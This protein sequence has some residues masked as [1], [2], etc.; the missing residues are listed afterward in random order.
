MDF[1]SSPK[2]LSSA[3]PTICL[4]DLLIASCALGQ[5]GGSRDLSTSSHDLLLFQL[6]GMFFQFV[7]VIATSGGNCQKQTKLE[8]MLNFYFF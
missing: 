5:K 3:L 1:L 4:V 6:A 2:F 7:N 8:M